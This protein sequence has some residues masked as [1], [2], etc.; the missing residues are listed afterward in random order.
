[1]ELLNKIIHSEALEFLKTLKSKSV[2]LVLIDPPYAIDKMNALWDMTKINKSI[3]S[4]I[5]TKNVVIGIPAGM[6][7][8][9]KH[10]KQLQEFLEPIFSEYLRVLKPG[11]FCLVF[12]QARSSYR[13]ALG[14]ELSG[15]EVRDQLFW[16]Y[17]TGQQ[18]AQSIVNFVNKNKN[19]SD[20]EKT[21]LITETRHK[22]TPQLAPCFETIW[23]AQKPKEGNTV[24]N[25][26][27]YKTG[28]VN[29][30]NETVKVKFTYPKTPI[31]E[32]DINY[33]HPT[34]KPEKLIRELIYRFS[35]SG[36]VI[37]DTFVGSGTTALCSLQLN[38]NFLACDF[39]NK[40]VN[41]GNFRIKAALDTTN[42]GSIF[43]A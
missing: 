3:D 32:K 43:N 35:N 10:S 18:K 40:F 33:K 34:Q 17:G 26:L 31:A 30:N 19:L 4:Q 15:F 36:D 38:R 12:S 9:M 41:S 23:L 16:D 28:L 29:F 42:T 8:D 5:V 39:N 7:F 20:T 6:K 13:V 14:L 24:E 27:K 21:N 25:Y 22:K 37:L 11:G 2:D 1:L